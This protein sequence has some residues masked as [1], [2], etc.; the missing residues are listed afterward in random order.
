[1]KTAEVT[2]LLGINRDRIRYFRKQGV[3]EPEQPA[4]DTAQEYTENDVKK[5]MALIVLTKAGLSC[6]DIRRM[7]EGD[8]TLEQAAEARQYL[9][10]EEFRRMH[11][12]MELLSDFL[13]EGAQFETLDV[14]RYWEWLA[15]REA[16]GQEF[17]DIMQEQNGV[18]IHIE[19]PE[20]KQLPDVLKRWVN[21]AAS[22]I[23]SPSRRD[24]VR[25]DLSIQLLQSFRQTGGDAVGVLRV[26]GPAEEEAE[27]NAFINKLPDRGQ[28]KVWRFITGML[29]VFAVICIVAL[30]LMDVPKLT[31]FLNSG[32][33]P[34]RGM[35]MFGPSTGAPSPGASGT[36]LV[37]SAITA[38]F[39]GRKAAKE[40]KKSDTLYAEFEALHS[41][42]RF[43]GEPFGGKNPQKMRSE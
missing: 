2:A 43:T 23:E 5:L 38:V 27:K 36:F 25:A 22:K 14:A 9:I 39:T 42:A 12:S 8:W 37:V 29:C 28:W 11:G 41:R 31:A 24:E 17:I 7:Q 15:Q 26:Y 19:S 35:P 1:M 13:A 10:E 21:I 20:Y 30:L 18:K 34:Y 3:F 16:E 40:K 32:N 33:H 4:E 6:G